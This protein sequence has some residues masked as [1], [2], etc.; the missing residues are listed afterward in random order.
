MSRR[1]LLAASVVIGIVGSSVAHGESGLD[2]EEEPPRLGIALLESALVLGVIG[3]FYWTGPD[4]RADS[5]DAD[6]SWNV[7]GWTRKLSLDVVRFDT[8]TFKVNAVRHSVMG[9]VTY[10]TGR[11]NG[12]GI[13]GSTVLALV[14][15]VVWEFFVEY[16]EYPSLNDLI[17][18]TTSGIQIGEPLYQI[19]QLWRGGVLTAGDRIKTTLF[20]PLDG[21]HDVLRRRHPLWARPQAWRSIVL[22]AGGTRHWSDGPRERTEALLTA[23]IDVVR[24]RNYVRSG[25]RAGAIKP[26]TWSRIRGQVRIGDR[27]DG[28]EHLASQ[29]RS[30]TALVGRYAQDDA[31]NGVF[32][33]LGTAFTYHREYLA[34]GWDHV[35]IAHLVGPQLQLSRRTPGFAVRWDLAGYGDFALIDAHVFHGERPFAPAPPHVTK[36]QTG[37]YYDGVGVSG[38]SR[39][40]VDAP[41]WTA[42]LELDVHRIWKIDGRE[43][44]SYHATALISPGA[45]DV[46]DTR[47]YWRAHL[48]VRSGSLGLTAVAEGGMAYGTHGDDH[49][50]TTSTMVG[51]IAQLTL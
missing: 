47:L 34:R 40:R 24:D 33:G 3:G 27:G 17:I 12:L 37:G 9:V 1:S 2:E 41:W 22:G 15:S 39:L 46:S 5:A 48:G 21:A 26:G 31:G 20:S 10:H 6:L 28:T 30:R 42:D 4:A 14:D 51:L 43:R 13:V 38:S 18:N 25:P 11:T 29:L 44:E 45:K 23:D 7:N 19:G 50:H 8:N 49:R 36:L 16:R 32:A 35:A